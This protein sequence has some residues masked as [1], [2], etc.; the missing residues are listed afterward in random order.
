MSAKLGCPCNRASRITRVLALVAANLV[1]I[2]L[3]NVRNTPG[4]AP[5]LAKEKRDSSG[6]LHS[7][8]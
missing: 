1:K 4:M 5:R 7:S 6:E 8:D 2:T 3:W